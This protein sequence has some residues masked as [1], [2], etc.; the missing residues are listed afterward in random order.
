MKKKIKLNLGC[1]KSIKKKF[2][3]LDFYKHPNT[4]VDI[5][6]NLNKKMPFNDSSIDYIYSSHLLE[7]LTW[8]KGEKLIKDCFRVLKK[9]GKIRI[10]IPD[11]KK[12]FKCYI[13]KDVRFFKVFMNNLNYNDL[14]YYSEVYQNPNKIKKERKGNLPPKWH[15][16][17]KKKDRENVALRSRKYNYLIEV[18]DWMVHQYGEHQSLYDS[19]SLK[20][21]FINAGFKNFKKVKYNYNIDI[22]QYAR[23]IISICFEA[24]K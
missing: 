20:A 7:H 8:I 6:A 14:K 22:K 11:F 3:N 13:N 10:L 19:E 24:K 4:K 2:I 9:G 1:G 15:L 23:K 5:I 21:I 12:I 17:R 18:V 16:S